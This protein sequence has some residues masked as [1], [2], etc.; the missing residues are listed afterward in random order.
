MSDAQSNP[1]QRSKKE[2][3]T[4]DIAIMQKPPIS[5]DDWEA[6][7]LILAQQ[8]EKEQIHN[9]AFE[10]EPV[11]IRLEPGSEKYS[12]RHI[13]CWV[14]GVGIEFLLNNKWWPNWPG[15]PAGYAP[16]GTVLTTKRK[17]VGVL[18]LSKRD[19]IQTNVLERDNEDPQNYV[20]RFTSS[21]NAFSVIEDRNPKGAAWLTDL[22]SRMG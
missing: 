7:E 15:L 20:E 22:R 14:N 13:A 11:T 10:E 18:A 9:L 12:P 2:L 1:V 8:C 17:Y 16:V 4:D 6:S 5:E 19:T 21:P 3:H